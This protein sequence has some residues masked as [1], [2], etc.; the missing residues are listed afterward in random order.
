M[1][2]AII[3]SE[4][5][6]STM[7]LDIDNDVLLLLLNFVYTGK[8]SLRSELVWNVL[9]AASQLELRDAPELCRKFIDTYLSL[10]SASD[11]IHEVRNNIDWT[12]KWVL[13]V[14]AK[15]VLF[16][17]SAAMTILFHSDRKHN[18]VKTVTQLKLPT[19]YSLIWCRQWRKSL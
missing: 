11:H 17:Q 13:I 9:T 14:T 16:N 2:I 4:I 5:D 8:L 15:N 12:L 3:A 7:I 18:L 19:L 6:L 10:N 1:C